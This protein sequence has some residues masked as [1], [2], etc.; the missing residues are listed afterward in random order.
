MEEE[1]K[2]KYIC[3]LASMRGLQGSEGG[4][5]EK[6]KKKKRGYSLDTNVLI[7]SCTLKL[8]FKCQL[9]KQ[10]QSKTKQKQKQQLK[11][12]QKQKHKQEHK[13]KHKQKHTQKRKCKE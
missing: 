6:D 3:L 1:E 7:R 9:S 5:Q 12:K 4:N 10:D 2:I 13:Q 8:N 11:H